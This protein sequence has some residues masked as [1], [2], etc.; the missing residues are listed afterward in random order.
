V[1]VVVSDADAP[2]V[3]KPD[4]APVLLVVDDDAS[5]RRALARL[6]TAAG[7]LVETF[8]SAQELLAREPLTGPG[9]LILDVRM[10]G[11]SGLDLQAMLRATGAEKATIFVSGHD[12]VPASVRAMKG[13][14]VDFLTK[15]IDD[16]QLFE[17]IERALARDRVERED[18]IELAELRRRLAT[19]TPRE[20]EVCAL[21]ATGR[22]NK[23]IAHLLG[24]SEKTIKVHRARVMAK[25]KVTSLVAL[26]RVA[27]R[28]SLR[29]PGD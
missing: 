9:C 10:P 8:G 18:H 3:A 15:P 4:S 29:P 16:A 19:L 2:A 24:T 26:V 17:A 25:M 5:V 11:L 1:E 12:D 23:Q 27:D 14:A 21:V 6:L 22:L 20:R 13:G 28:L 7:Y